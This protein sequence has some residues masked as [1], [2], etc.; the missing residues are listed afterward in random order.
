[1]SAWKESNKEVRNFSGSALFLKTEP[2]DLLGKPT[3]LSFFV[4]PRVAL[5]FSHIRPI[6]LVK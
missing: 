1:M 2:G 5:G 6:R 3:Q 4:G